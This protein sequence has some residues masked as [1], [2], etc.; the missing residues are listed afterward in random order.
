MLF[1]SRRAFTALNEDTHR[2]HEP[3]FLLT[4]EVPPTQSTAE[5]AGGDGKKRSPLVSLVEDQVMAM[6]RLGVSAE[7]LTS[8]TDQENKKRIMK[9]M[10]EPGSSL[11]LLYVTPE[12]CS[13]SKQFMAK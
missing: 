12:K 5:E 6:Q 13:K 3:H 11:K 1:F 7:M 10:L 2:Q 8:S 4:T 9:E